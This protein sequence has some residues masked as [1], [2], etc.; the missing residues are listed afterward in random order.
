MYWDELKIRT[1]YKN[2]FVIFLW[3]ES[4][5]WHTITHRQ[6]ILAQA[7]IDKLRNLHPLNEKIYIKFHPRHYE[8]LDNNTIDNCIELISKYNNLDFVSIKFLS[9]NIP[10]IY[11]L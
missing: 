6:K 2:N 4:N 9:K 7:I 11:Y 10:M 1:N 8:K 5:V 3:P